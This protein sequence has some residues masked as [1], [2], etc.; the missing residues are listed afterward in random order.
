M[1]PDSC[2]GYLS[3]KPASP[4]CAS[5]ASMRSRNSV[6]R[7]ARYSC[8]NGAHDLKRQHHVVAQSSA[9]AAASGSGMPCRRER[10]R[11]RLRGR[12]R[13]RPA[14][15]RDQPGHQLEDRRLAA[16]GRADQRDEVALLDPQIGGVERVHPLLAAAIGMR[17]LLQLDERVDLGDLRLRRWACA[18]CQARS[19]G[20]AG[21]DDGVHG[22]VGVARRRAACLDGVDRA[23]PAARIGHQ[24]A[25]AH[26]EAAAHQRVDRQA[27]DAHGRSR[28]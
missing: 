6:L 18:S 17:H 27:V 10:A 20:C 16:A 15:R 5:S 12:Q 23:A 28:A 26:D 7:L 9:T 19:D 1:P 24:R 25:V 4:T 11:R 14:R 8:R 22:L 3:P 2:Q 21:T 13:A